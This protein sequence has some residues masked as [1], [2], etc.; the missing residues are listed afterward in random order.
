[1]DQ[2][3]DFAHPIIIREKDE[4]TPHFESIARKPGEIHEQ[5]AIARRISW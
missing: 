1:L 5:I 2:C 4:K 3:R